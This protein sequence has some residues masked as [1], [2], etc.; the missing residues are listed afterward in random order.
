[1]R[2]GG[3]HVFID[4]GEVG[5]G[6][7]TGAGHGH[8]DILSFELVLDG[9]RILTDCGS[10]VYTASRRW[11]NHFRATAMHNTVEVDGAEIN[12]FPSDDDLWRLRED[13]HPAG[14]VFRPGEPCDY[15]RGS[16]TGYNRDPHQVRHT[17]EIV[18]DR[19]EPLL[20]IRD[21]LSGRGHHEVTWR[22]H[23]V[24]GTVA[25]IEGPAIRARIAG[26]EAWL[27]ALDPVAGAWRIEDSWVSS[28]YGVREAAPVAVLT[29]AGTVPM[30]AGFAVTTT[31]CDPAAARR[32]FSECEA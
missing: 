22:F 21:R 6:Q 7:G 18:L 8:N 19:R 23:F 12:R 9:T 24:P 5:M 15:F 11:R 2:G 13:A 14:V 10:Y 29:R 32:A 31:P 26:R 16:H 20:A 28:R 25:T 17:R 27:T 4:C 1:M 3:H 30:A